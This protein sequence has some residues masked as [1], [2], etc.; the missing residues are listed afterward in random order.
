MSH[1]QTKQ[2]VTQLL[3]M[4]YPLSLSELENH[5]Q[6]ILNKYEKKM[7]MMSEF[8]SE[9]DVIYEEREKFSLHWAYKNA[10]FQLNKHLQQIDQH[11]QENTV[12]EPR[13]VELTKSIRHDVKGASNRYNYLSKTTL[14]LDIIISVLLILGVT[15]LAQSIEGNLESILLTTAFIGGIAL[16]K[17][18]LDRFL[19]IPYIDEWGWTRYHDLTHEIEAK[20]SKIL[21]FKIAVE[22]DIHE[23]EL[24]R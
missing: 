17:V 22:I 5:R 24:L 6:E 8:Y 16:S 21:A 23:K 20:T 18:S 7:E 2:T 4:E 14:A 3:E 1:I 19:I 10:S 11:I 15:M 12:T 9:L 13:M